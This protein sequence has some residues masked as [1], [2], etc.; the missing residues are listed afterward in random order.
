MGYEEHLL[1]GR[2]DPLCVWITTSRFHSHTTMKKPVIRAVLTN[3]EIVVSVVILHTI[4][5]MNNSADRQ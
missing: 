5:V 2:T 3:Y 4:G 1:T